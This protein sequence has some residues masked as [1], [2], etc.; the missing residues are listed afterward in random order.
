MRNI[1]EVESRIEF[2]VQNA[3]IAG[4]VD[5]ILKEDAVYEVRDYKTSDEVLSKDD[6]KLQVQLYSQG[7]R[8]LGWDIQHGSIAYI[9]E[10]Q[11]DTVDVAQEKVVEA[12]KTAENTINNII[13]GCYQ[14]NPSKFCVK[15]DYSNICRWVKNA[16]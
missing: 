15:C 12:R 8:N 7:L 14:A 5:V 9:K 10:S 16:K 4:K 6:A 2:P 11:L 13:G 3:T 1:E